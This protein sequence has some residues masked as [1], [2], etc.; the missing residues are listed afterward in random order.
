VFDDDQYLA[1]EQKY[2]TKPRF[3][4][5]GSRI[6]FPKNQW[7]HVRW[8]MFMDDINGKVELWQDG[9]KIV[10]AYG[11]TIPTFN[12]VQT[13]LEIGISA[14]STATVLYMDNILLVVSRK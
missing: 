4:Q 10:D 14:T 7:V 6:A 3:S 11:K 12:S 9:T 13:N 5:T 2:G 8:K 1:V